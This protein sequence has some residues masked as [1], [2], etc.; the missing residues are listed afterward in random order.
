MPAQNY[1]GDRR[2]RFTGFGRLKRFGDEF[3]NRYWRGM[4]IP[5]EERGN[6]GNSGWME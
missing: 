5:R 1:S 2:K 4:P 3:Q 6:L